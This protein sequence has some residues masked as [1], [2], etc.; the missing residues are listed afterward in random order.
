MVT[1]PNGKVDGG[2]WIPP[3]IAVR[4]MVRIVVRIMVRCGAVVW[5]SPV[6]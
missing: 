2:R 4:I 5:C 1:Q 6:S 3:G